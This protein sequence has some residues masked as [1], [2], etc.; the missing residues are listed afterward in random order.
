MEEKLS[1]ILKKN[2]NEYYEKHKKD[3]KDY[4]D[5]G[6]EETV[7]KINYVS[8]EIPLNYFYTYGFKRFDNKKCKE[9]Q[10]IVKEMPSYKGVL[11]KYKETLNFFNQRNNDCGLYLDWKSTN[12][13]RSNELNKIYTDK[14]NEFIDTRINK[15]KNIIDQKEKLINRMQDGKFHLDIG[16]NDP[17]EC[18]LC[19]KIVKK[20]PVY[21]NINIKFKKIREST[22]CKIFLDWSII[23][24]I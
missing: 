18:S 4:I 12:K 5:N 13:E 8:K 16:R 14:I 7:K 10:K 2:L 19:N 11:L 17:I 9:F 1:D 6:I 20:L 24:K 23:K 21:K 15:I 22:M 3:I